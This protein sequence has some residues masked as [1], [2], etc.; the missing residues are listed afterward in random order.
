MWLENL[1]GMSFKDIEDM[2]NFIEGA[3]GFTTTVCD[4]SIIADDNGNKII[5]IF[6]YSQSGDRYEITNFESNK[7]LEI[8]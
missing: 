1:I 7:L 8:K 5:Y 4:N 2:M 6:T 3:F